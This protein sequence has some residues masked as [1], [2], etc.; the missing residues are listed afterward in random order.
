MKQNRERCVTSESVDQGDEVETG[1]AVAEI[2]IQKVTQ[3]KTKQKQKLQQLRE[4]IE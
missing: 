2:Y 1:N 3:E 4:Q